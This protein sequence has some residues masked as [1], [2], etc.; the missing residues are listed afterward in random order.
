MQTDIGKKEVKSLTG[1]GSRGLNYYENI[2]IARLTLQ[3]MNFTHYNDKT[4][5][6]C[7]DIVKKKI[8]E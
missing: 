2:E 3:L 8:L 7:F 5:V 6:E 1:V 4:F